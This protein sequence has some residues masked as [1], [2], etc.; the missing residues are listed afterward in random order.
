MNGHSRRFNGF[1]MR[2][3][4]EDQNFVDMKEV[5]SLLRIF[6]NLL[7][8]VLHVRQPLVMERRKELFF[9]LCLLDV[10]LSAAINRR[11]KRIKEGGGAKSV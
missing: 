5:D 3:K 9:S 6:R 11:R 8:T 7:D 1:R 2:L 10:S 4:G